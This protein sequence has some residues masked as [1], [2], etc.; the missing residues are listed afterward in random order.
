MTPS[1]SLFRAA[2]SQPLALRCRPDL[3]I[4]PQNYRRERYWLVKDPVALSYFHLRDEEHAI[5]RMLDG[6]TGA[7]E[8]KARFDKRF[9]PYLLSL[10]QLQAFLGRLHECGLILSDA[11]GQGAQLLERTG[12][13]GWRNWA[14]A[15]TNL[16]AIRFRGIDPEPF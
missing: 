1:P 3:A 2:A 5:L 14:A 6:R 16:L 10:E 15:W 4:S 11:Q 7:A 8:I 13:R 9:A 12:S